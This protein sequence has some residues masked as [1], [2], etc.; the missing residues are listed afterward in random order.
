MYNKC[1][2]TN[3]KWF[4]FNHKLSSLVAIKLINCIALRLTLPKVVEIIDVKM[5]AINQWTSTFQIV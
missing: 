5:H 2:I 3:F 1:F 4:V